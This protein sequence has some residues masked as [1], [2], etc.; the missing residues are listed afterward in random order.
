MSLQY[1]VAFYYP[2]QWK[3]HHPHLKTLEQ[4]VNL[5]QF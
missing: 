4:N 1:P 5:Y 2:L 3:E